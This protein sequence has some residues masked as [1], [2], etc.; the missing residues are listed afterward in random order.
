MFRIAIQPDQERLT[1]GR[2]QSFSDH[3]IGKLRDA[4]HEPVVVEAGRDGFFDE[5]RRCD[6]FMWWFAHVSYP[7]EF[8][9]RVVHAVQHGCRIP[10]FPTWETVWHFDDKVAQYYLLRAAGIPTARTSILWHYRDAIDFCLK[11]QYPLVIKLSSGITSENVRL[12]K[13]AEEARYWVGR[14]FGSGVV[15]WSARRWAG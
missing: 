15:P 2:E 14:M 6:G 9:R 5:V 1:S 7:R 4:G 8:A 12:L 10:T 3:W 11:A 13:N